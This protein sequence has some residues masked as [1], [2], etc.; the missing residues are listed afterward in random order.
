MKKGKLK[1]RNMTIKQ[2][3]KGT[4]TKSDEQCMDIYCLFVSVMSVYYPEL[5]ELKINAVDWGKII[6]C[7]MITMVYD[8][9]NDNII[10]KYVNTEKMNV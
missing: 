8:R 6:D 4:L 10:E 5:Q 1:D 2:R 9:H 7:F 3:F